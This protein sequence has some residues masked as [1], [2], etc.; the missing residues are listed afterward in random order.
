MIYSWIDWTS[1]SMKKTE[2]SK[3]FSAHILYQYTPQKKGN[4]EKQ[5]L[6]VLL[7]ESF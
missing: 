4:I 5:S 7:R 1:L 2:A 6:K 3:R